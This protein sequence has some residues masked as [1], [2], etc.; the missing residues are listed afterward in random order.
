MVEIV[1]KSS[2]VGFFSF[3]NNPD[4][5][6]TLIFIG[7]ELLLSD[8]L[9]NKLREALPPP[10]GVRRSPRIVS[11]GYVPKRT[12]LP[13]YYYNLGLYCPIVTSRRH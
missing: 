12:L 6:S 11:Y 5:D 7:K 10:P 3:P 8:N 13:V 4:V 1:L 9:V 2:P